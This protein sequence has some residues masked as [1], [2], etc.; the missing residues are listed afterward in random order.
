MPAYSP[1]LR[2]ASSAPALGALHP[3]QS[4]RSRRAAV[5]AVGELAFD[6]FATTRA[7]PVLVRMGACRAA[8]QKLPQQF[9]GASKLAIIHDPYLADVGGQFADAAGQ[10]FAAHDGADAVRFEITAN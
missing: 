2:A 4:I 1:L 3:P 10:K 5:P 6:G 7:V 9:I 8:T